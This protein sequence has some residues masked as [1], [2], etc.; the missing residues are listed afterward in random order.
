MD[1]IQSAIAQAKAAAGDKDVTVIGTGKV[2]HSNASAQVSTDE[3]H[4]DNNAG[5]AW[6]GLRL[7]EDT[8]HGTNL[9]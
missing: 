9:N 2:S 7:F 4:I 5:A 3:L 6:R 8:G 1:G